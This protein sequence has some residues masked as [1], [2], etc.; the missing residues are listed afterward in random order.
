ME[1]LLSDYKVRAIVLRE[2]MKDD[3]ISLQHHEVFTKLEHEVESGRSRGKKEDYIG[4]F[5]TGAVVKLLNIQ[6][7]RSSNENANKA[8]VS[9]K[10][11]VKLATETKP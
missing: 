9:A 8:K 4:V 3:E 7:D 11:E 2:A 5:P 6:N 10:N 1:N